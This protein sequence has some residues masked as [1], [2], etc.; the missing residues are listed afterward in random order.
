MYLVHMKSFDAIIIGFGKG[1]KTLAAKLASSE[2]T[3]ALI[4]KSDRMYGGTCI[5][6]GCIPSKSLV[7]SSEFINKQSGLSFEEKSKLYSSAIA[8]KRRVTSMLRQKNFDKL[9]QMKNVTI[10][11]GT[12]SFIT[13]TEVKVVNGNDIEILSAPKIYINTGAK[14]I[15]P[16]IKGLSECKNAYVSETMMDL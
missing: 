1:G 11:N 6:V 13:N 10:F 16:D 8:E 4:E 2:K 15:I 9:N 3:V 14:P 7:N 12:G 5:N